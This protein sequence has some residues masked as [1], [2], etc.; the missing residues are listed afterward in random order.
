MIQELKK[1]GKMPNGES[2]RMAIT[3][4]HEINLRELKARKE[5][6]EVR[7]KY[8]RKLN[9]ALDEM[10]SL[11]N[12]GRGTRETA[13]V[14]ADLTRIKL[15]LEEIASDPRSAHTPGISKK[16]ESAQDKLDWLQRRWSIN[17]DYED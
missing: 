1:H 10:N 6:N 11:E 13:A 9:N 7:A 5:R 12:R 16:L 15:T 17:R 4:A 14:K 8:Q 3:S 2:Y